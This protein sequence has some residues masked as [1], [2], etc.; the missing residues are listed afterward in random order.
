MIVCCCACGVDDATKK[1]IACVRLTGGFLALA[2][3]ARPTTAGSYEDIVVMSGSLD[4]ERGA[5]DVVIGERILF[6]TKSN[7]ARGEAVEKVPRRVEGS[8]L[9]AIGQKIMKPQTNAPS[10]GLRK[11][12]FLVRHL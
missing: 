6:Q 9:M 8:Q 10:T 1:D 7:C 11:N 5:A 2:A 12:T 3:R 4:N